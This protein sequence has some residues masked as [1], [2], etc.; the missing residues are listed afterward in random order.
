[1]TVNIIIRNG[2]I[3]LI[4]KFVLISELYKFLTNNHITE[5]KLKLNPHTH[6]YMCTKIFW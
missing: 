6:Y 1:M 4:Y 3:E 2:I 5:Q